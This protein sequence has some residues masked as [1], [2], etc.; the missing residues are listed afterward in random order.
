[1]N[2][3]N[4]V[5]LCAIALMAFFVADVN[6][7]GRRGGQRGMMGGGGM[8][9][10]R[11]LN[12]EEVQEALD[13]SEEQIEKI[14]EMPG[15]RR[16][17]RGQ[18]GQRGQRGQRQEGDQEGQRQQ[19][20]QRGQRGGDAGARV[21]AEL[22]AIGEILKPAQVKRLNG[23]YIQAAGVGALNDPVVAKELE[24]TDEQKEEI[25]AVRQEI[26]QELREEMRERRDS[27]EGREEMME[28]FQEFQKEV[29]KETMGV[30]TDS[31]KKKLESLKGKK[32]ELPERG[33][34]GRGGQRG[35]GGN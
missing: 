13:L 29:E 23:I 20:G 32:V 33:G 7:Q 4:L 28:L 27:G 11:L 34:R 16:G 2:Q 19:R 5:V 12:I 21:E 9:R 31:Q 10:T 26:G 35:G 8:S 17:Q 18:G 30:L 25:Q 14:G 24:I 6:A 15:A 1:M 3:R 22:K